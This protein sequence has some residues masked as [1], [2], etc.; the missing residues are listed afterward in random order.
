[1]GESG[2]VGYAW[3]VAEAGAATG[4]EDPVPRLL[5]DRD[6]GADVG[7]VALPWPARP[8]ECAPPPLYSHTP[9]YQ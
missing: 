5:G 1:M 2:D 8:G 4:E 7:E 9:H 3:A 6:R